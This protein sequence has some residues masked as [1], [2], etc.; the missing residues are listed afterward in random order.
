MPSPERVARVRRSRIFASLLVVL[1]SG[2]E[3][4]PT[5]C[6]EEI[7]FEQYLELIQ[8]YR[9]GDFTWTVEE[10]APATKRFIDRAG[11]ELPRRTAS[12]TDRKAAVLLHT[13]TAVLKE[14]QGETQLRRAHFDAARGICGR[15]SDRNF[16]QNWLL[17]LG[18]YHQA[19]LETETAVSIF[20]AIRRDFPPNS[21]TLLALGTVYEVKGSFAGGPKSGLS[22]HRQPTIA[23]RKEREGIRLRGESRKNLEKAEEYY[24]RAIDERGGGSDG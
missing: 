1:I 5:L 3:L 22:S 15:L 7:S 4:A 9:E 10:L 20:E 19:L 13:Q 12:E 11:R 18:Y 16:E 14:N 21:E 17:A 8:R 23:V 24:R 6:G 2:T